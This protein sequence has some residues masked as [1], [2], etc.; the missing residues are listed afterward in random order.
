[1]TMIDDGALCAIGNGRTLGYLRGADLVCLFGPHYSSPDLGTLSWGEP[2]FADGELPVDANYRVRTERGERESFAEADAP[3]LSWRWRLD[4]DES[5]RIRA[6]VVD[7]KPI[8]WH[9]VDAL[10]VTGWVAEIPR[11]AV[12]FRYPV[13]RPH[14]LLV[15]GDGV[16]EVDAADGVLT[17][18]VAAG[19]GWLSIVTGDDFA[20]TLDA[21]REVGRTT[22]HARANAALTA[23]LARTAGLVA[24]SAAGIAPDLWRLAADQILAQQ[25]RDGGFVA[26]HRYALCY[27]RDQF[28]TCEGLAALGFH[29]AVR[30]NILFRFAA[31]RRFGDLA[32]A[33]SM[34]PD[35]IRHRHENDFVEQ[36][37]YMVL[38]VTRYVDAT[39]DTG[40]L[41]EVAPML[42]WCLDRQSE[43]LVGGALPFNGDETYVAG[44]VLPRWALGD[45][46]FEAT[47]LYLAAIE[48]LRVM[49]EEFSV[50]DVFWARQDAAAAEIRAQWEANFIRGDE[51]IITNS[52]R[53]RD[54]VGEDAPSSRH[55]VC[56]RCHNFPTTTVRQETGRYVCHRCTTIELEPQPRFELEIASTTLFPA[57]VVTDL[58]GDDRFAAIAARALARWA[59]RGYLPSDEGGDTAVGYDEGLLLRA[60]M[61]TAE[62]EDARR[63]AQ[64]TA[65]RADR[66]GT[67]AEYY[68]HGAHPD[69]T[70]CR[71]WETGLNI[72]ALVAF[73]RVTAITGAPR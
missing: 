34:S 65:A 4:A 31:F 68:T 60:L 28:G 67:W 52:L 3:A 18:S 36:T 1:M 66:F 11:G 38:Q 63:V 10:G 12:V 43:Q 9:R 61:A 49:R 7:A 64:G 2:G 71:P 22:V 62:P 45:G 47:L 35:P 8:E 73:A 57:L 37:G 50:D 20:E 51:G 72:A 55:G 23:R 48:R 56:E 41:R 13:S 32:N 39:G 44:G 42:T 54:L 5:V 26:G 25:A 53:R 46:S 19:A 59:E 21:A 33:E 69:G 24:P 17:L 14:Y 16:A 29:D 27:L 58:I 15:I 6:G 70:R 40:I 30:A